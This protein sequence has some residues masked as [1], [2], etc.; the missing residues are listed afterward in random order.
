MSNTDPSPD[1]PDERCDREGPGPRV[2]EGRLEGRLWY[3]VAD[4]ED[5]RALAERLVQATDCVV[6]V[7]ASTGE[8]TIL[9]AQRAGRVVAVEKAAERVASLQELAREHDNV[10]VFQAEEGTVASVLP[11]LPRAADVLLVDVGGNAPVALAA[12]LCLEYARALDPRCVVFRNRRFHEYLLSLSLADAAE[13]GAQRPGDLLQ[14]KEG[15]NARLARHEARRLARAV[16]EAHTPDTARA[17]AH[18]L[19]GANHRTRRVLS[20]ALKLLGE[21]ACEPLA[22][23]LADPEAPLR[24]RRESASLLREIGVRLDL[25]SLRALARHPA[26]GVQW[27]ATVALI[28]RHRRL[29]AT[30]GAAEPVPPGAALALAEEARRPLPA[31]VVLALLESGDGIAEWLARRH[32]RRLAP[33]ST[34]LIVEAFLADAVADAQVPLALAALGGVDGA[35]ARS[36]PAALAERPAEEA[37]AALWRLASHCFGLG[38]QRLARDLLGACSRAW[39][40]AGLPVAE[41]RGAAVTPVALLEALWTGKGDAWSRERIA[42]VTAALAA[43]GLDLAA[44]LEAGSGSPHAAMREACARAADW[45]R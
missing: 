36:L 15:R 24:A 8:A 40:E 25:G 20:D 38:D 16:M 39:A 42:E 19:C 35:A 13:G 34:R 29:G 33:A 10:E 5:Y 2:I 11:A 17:L 30:Y 41:H 9:L 32:L 37:R 26:V 44:A 7:G 43:L 31:Q 27:V 45:L 4:V 1:R 12:P 14:A 21:E 23:L 6:E 28:E 18:A 22:E 3:V